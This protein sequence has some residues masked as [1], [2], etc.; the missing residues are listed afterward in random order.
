MNIFQLQGYYL[1]KRAEDQAELDG[2]ITTIV[3][4]LNKS[5]QLVLTVDKPD[6]GFIF[7]SYFL[8]FIF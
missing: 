3:D 4:T 1:Q 2:L 8:L 5:S 6:E 7:L